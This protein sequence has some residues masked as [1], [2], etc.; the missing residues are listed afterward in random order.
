[1]IIVGRVKCVLYGRMEIA[2]QLLA[3]Q[4]SNKMLNLKYQVF[5]NSMILDEITKKKY[6]N[7]NLKRYFRQ[8]LFPPPVFMARSSNKHTSASFLIVVSPRCGVL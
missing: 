2:R 5:M 6:L 8:N 4:M 3:P 1:M 7:K